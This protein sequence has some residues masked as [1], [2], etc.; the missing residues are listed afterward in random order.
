[1]ANVN[2]TNISARR[3]GLMLGDGIGHE[4]VP[5]T[6]QVVD[7]AVTAAGAPEIEWVPLDLGR[8][9]IATHGTPVPERTL[10]TLATLDSW[11]LGP[12]DSAS[13]PEPFRSQLPPGGTIR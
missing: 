4:I 13:Y 7:T 11:I 12:H 3:I 9:A 2:A 5:A 6:R 8:D 1:M 10:D